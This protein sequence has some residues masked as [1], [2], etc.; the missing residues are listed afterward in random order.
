M[1]P[2]HLQCA[3][4]GDAFLKG[5]PNQIYCSARCRK[6][7]HH[8]RR[9]SKPHTKLLRREQN[10][11]HRLRHLERERERCRQWR[12]RQRHIVESSPW[13]ERFAY[14]G[15]DDAPTGDMEKRES[16][17]LVASVRKYLKWRADSCWDR[18]GRMHPQTS[19]YSAA[20][21][22]LNQA[23]LGPAYETADDQVW[24]TAL[25]EHIRQFLPSVCFDAERF[26][27]ELKV[28]RLHKLLDD[29]MQEKRHTGRR[30]A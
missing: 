19:A 29:A 15:R 4:C 24:Q 18:F 14:Q 17:E 26:D 9:Y 22:V 10:Q 1:S 7:E 11:R 2:D 6:R 25:T 12:R 28:K 13:L 16:K 20:V 27:R 21:N 30:A 5:P 8:K 3:H 23:Q